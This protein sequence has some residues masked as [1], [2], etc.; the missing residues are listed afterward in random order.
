M[1]R[2]NKKLWSFN[3][4][5]IISGSFIWF[6]DLSK[7]LPIPKFVLSN[8]VISIDL[9][10]NFTVVCLAVLLTSLL[11]W[12]MKSMLNVHSSEHTFWLVLP[13]L[14]F[15]ILTAVVAN[16]LIMTML[17][18]AIPALIVILFSARKKKERRIFDMEKAL[19]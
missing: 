12:V 19:N 7:S 1:P 5:C 3:V 8:Q 17:N 9:Y 4:G 18:A 10:F 16:V 15:L 13:I 11:M 14:T 6:A 2:L